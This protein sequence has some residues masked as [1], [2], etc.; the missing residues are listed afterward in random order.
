MIVP[1]GTDHTHAWK[2]GEIKIL[3][4]SG[5]KSAY[6]IIKVWKCKCGAQKAYDIKERT[7]V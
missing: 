7:I 6:D 1:K 2:Y 5:I 4:T 3:L